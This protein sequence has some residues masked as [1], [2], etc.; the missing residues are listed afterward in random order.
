M[1]HLGNWSSGTT[2][3]DQKNCAQLLLL[4]GNR[5]QPTVIIKAHFGYMLSALEKSLCL[6]SH[7]QNQFQNLR[8]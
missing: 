3:I 6:S 4:V 8:L 2:K 1:E 5:T 7:N